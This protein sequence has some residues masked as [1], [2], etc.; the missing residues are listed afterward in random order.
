MTVLESAE[1]YRIKFLTLFSALRNQDR[2][3]DGLSVSYGNMRE[4][5]GE[6]KVQST[7]GHGARFTFVIPIHQESLP[8]E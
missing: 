2:G 1:I 4:H 8:N 7:P 6:I 3:P 5:D